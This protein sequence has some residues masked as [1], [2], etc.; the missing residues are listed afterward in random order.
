VLEL[1]VG[2]KNGFDQRQTL[3]TCYTTC[4]GSFP[5][6]APDVAEKRRFGPTFALGGEPVVCQQYFIQSSVTATVSQRLY[7]R[8]NGAIQLSK[9]A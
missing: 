4:I 2:N 9:C 1:D 3:L 8:A 6:Y 5:C 7:N